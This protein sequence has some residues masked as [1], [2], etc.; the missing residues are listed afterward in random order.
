[1][2]MKWKQNG[3]L[4]MKWSLLSLPSYGIMV[5]NKFTILQA[6]NYSSSGVHVKMHVPYECGQ[7]YQACMT[8]VE[9][10]GRIVYKPTHIDF[11]GHG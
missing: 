10:F 2:Y 8:V 3:V 11:A 9:T 7:I 1:M 4:R 5:V 6:C